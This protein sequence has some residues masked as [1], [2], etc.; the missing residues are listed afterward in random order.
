MRE[1][2]ARVRELADGRTV[3]NLFTYYLR[4]R[5]RRGGWWRC[6]R[7]EYRRGAPGGLLLCCANEMRLPR[8]AFRAACLQGLRAAGRAVR[9]R[10]FPGAFPVEFPVSPGTED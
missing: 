3:L 10:S 6:A 9:V 5:R 7:P 1:A 4:L 8:R 2:R